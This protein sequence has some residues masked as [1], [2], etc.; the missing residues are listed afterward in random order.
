M[1]GYHPNAAKTY[2]I[3]KAPYELKAARQL[4]S[5]T[6]VKITTSGKRHL[7][8]AIGSRSLTEV[9]MNNKVESCTKEIERLTEIVVSL[10]HAVYTAFTHVPTIRHN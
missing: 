5:D 10:P 6:A 8:A 1:F 7:G 9:Y 4:F 2:L 3:V